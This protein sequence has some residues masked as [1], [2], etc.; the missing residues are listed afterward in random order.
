MKLATKKN[1]NVNQ[2]I[3]SMRRNLEKLT[4]LMVG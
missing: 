2:N 3:V 4:V 1:E